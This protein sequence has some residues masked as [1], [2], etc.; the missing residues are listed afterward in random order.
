MT[1]ATL[2]IGDTIEC[3]VRGTTFSALY[4]GTDD[5]GLAKI[6]PLDPRHFS[7]RKVTARQV[8]RRVEVQECLEVAG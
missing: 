5:N 7:W 6:E 4:K 1:L 8:V 2:T 3:N